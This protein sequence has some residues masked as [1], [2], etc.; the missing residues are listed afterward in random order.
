MPG[1]TTRL[2]LCICLLPFSSAA[3]PGA[4]TAVPVD[5]EP[6][7]RLVFENQYIRVFQ[8]EVPGDAAT[9]LHRHDK[10]YVF[11]TLGDSEV[12]NER[13]AE[14]T[15]V[16]KLKDG[17]TRFVRGGFAHVA[18][19][20]ADK[21]FRNVTVEIMQPTGS[22]ICGAGRGVCA[23]A[24]GGTTGGAS[25][26]WR[27]IAESDVLTIRQFAITAQGSLENH[28]H[29]GPH[30]VIAITN[31]RLRN[32]V[33]GKPPAE[34]NQGAGGIK[35]IPGGFTHSVTNVGAEPARCVTVEF[36]VGTTHSRGRLCHTS[37]AGPR[38]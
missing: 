13:E 29:T 14:K 24:A 3:Q 25:V 17:E 1:V 9:L 31:L 26:S 2:V 4:T 22:F 37:I 21:P 12:S 5:K 8:V 38:F 33:E 18:R 20:L 19:N 11:V 28:Q 6:V 27:D 34:I 35:W 10:D 23:G 16:L 32:E 7:H 15:A 30:L 36:M